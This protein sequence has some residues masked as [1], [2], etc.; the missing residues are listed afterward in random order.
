MPTNSLCAA[1]I[2]LLFILLHIVSSASLLADE[3]WLSKTSDSMLEIAY[4]VTSY[5]PDASDLLLG[6]F[7]KM[8]FSEFQSPEDSIYFAG[9]ESQLCLWS[10]QSFYADTNAVGVCP[11]PELADDPM[12]PFSQCTLR[13][14]ARVIYYR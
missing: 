1:G 2:L 13:Q 11:P 3:I 9:K 7:A 6:S 5:D 4:L 10:N 8:M 12:H 14:R